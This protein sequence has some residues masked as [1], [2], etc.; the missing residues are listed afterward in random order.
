M[1]KGK[2]LDNRYKIVEQELVARGLLAYRIKFD[3]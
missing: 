1:D 2:W 3:T